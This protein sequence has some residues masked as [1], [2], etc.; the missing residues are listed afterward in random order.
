MSQASQDGMPSEDND[1]V[2]GSG[3]V[4]LDPESEEEFKI[5]EVKEAD[6]TKPKSAEN[7]AEEKPANGDEATKQTSSDEEANFDQDE[8]QPVFKT[9]KK[10]T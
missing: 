9:M 2:A 3:K 8:T 4:S 6:E 5:E 1:S 10:L 7:V